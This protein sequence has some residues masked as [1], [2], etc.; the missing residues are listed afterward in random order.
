MKKFKSL[1]LTVIGLLCSISVSAHDFEVDGIYYNIMS[2]TDMTVEVTYRGNK[3]NSYSE[4]YS[5]AVNIPESVTY[6]GKTYNVTSIGSS[7]F[8]DCSGLTSVVIPNSVTSIGSSAFRNCFSLTS[9]VIPN[10]VTSIGSGAFSN[11][12]SLTSVEIP[13]SVTSI[14]ESAFEDCE[15]LT[16]IVIPNSLTKIERRVFQ[17]CENLSSV[18]IPNSVTSI[19]N[20]AFW[21]CSSLTSVVIPNSVTSIGSSAFRDCRN[22]KVIFN[23]S[24]LI[25]TKGSTEHGY[26]AYYAEVIWN[27]YDQIGDFIFT[28][29]DGTNCLRAYIGNRH[30]L[31]L[32]ENYKEGS[33]AIGDYAFM[34]NSVLTSVEIP[35]SVTSI[36][37][38]AF[39]SCHN[40]QSVLIGN[41]VANIGKNAFG[42]CHLKIVLN[43]SSV[44]ITKSDFIAY[45][46]VVDNDFERDGD[47]VFSEEDNTYYLRVYTGDE[48]ELE[49]PA[50]FKGSNYEIGTYSFFKCHS[51]SKIVIPNSVTKIGSDAFDGCNNLTSIVIPNS[52]TSIGEYAFYNC[53]SL[54]SVEIGKNVTSIGGAAFY[55]C[56]NLAKIV[57]YAKEPPICG[58]N[59]WG[60]GAFLG[61]NKETCVLQVPQLCLAAYQQA[62]QWKDFLV[63]EDVLT[64]IGGITVDGAVPAADDVY[65]TNG[66]LIKRNAELKNLKHELP[67][68]IYIIG[69]KKVWV[70]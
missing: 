24:E 4:E 54:T 51:L 13:N 31:K 58:E 52:V 33:Y 37:D 14:G 12:S 48:S 5:G 46:S 35:N 65:S 55:D 16:S 57:C 39:Y 68:G 15:S 18:V 63:I 17:S 26:I 19:G 45:A 30:N 69:G 59:M 2:S 38:S 11:C 6:N 36:G 7:A 42:E 70:K 49:L 8:Y 64:S 40:L 67:A 3:Y 43:K 50:N 29:E 27:V 61:V 10:S 34:N 60:F 23:N 32:P 25:F 53:S 21:N 41:G 47:F 44:D 56:S 28:E 9:V 20:Y 22:L 62:D 1:V 66:M